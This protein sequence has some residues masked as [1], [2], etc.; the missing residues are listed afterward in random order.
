MGLANYTNQN[1]EAWPRLETLAERLGTTKPTVIENIKRLVDRGLVVKQRRHNS[2][3]VYQLQLNAGKDFELPAEQSKETLLTQS[4]E[5][6]PTKLRNLTSRGK[7]TLLYPIIE[8]GREPDMRGGSDY[9]QF[10]E[11]WFQQYKNKFGRK[12]HFGGKDGFILKQLLSQYTVAEI[13]ATALR[14]LQST[15]K[16][17]ASTARD[18]GILSSQWNKL[19]AA[20]SADE[21]NEAEFLTTIP[22]LF[23]DYG[24]KKR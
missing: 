16:F 10:V 1:N 13:Q 11:W 21:V 12:Y 5:T 8:P 17:I 3:S 15:D 18:I 14:M 4:K 2:S 7:E 23:S 19:A 24:K 6:L 20:A 22:P 9:K